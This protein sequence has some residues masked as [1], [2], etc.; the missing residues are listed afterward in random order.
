MQ[1]DYAMSIY[2]YENFGGPYNKTF[3]FNDRSI[4]VLLLVVVVVCNTT[5]FEGVILFIFS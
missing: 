3:Y 1:Y 4:T 2:M 5:E